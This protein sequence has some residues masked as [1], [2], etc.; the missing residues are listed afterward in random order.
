MIGKRC[1]QKR[2]PSPL[3]GEHL[4]FFVNDNSLY[5]FLFRVAFVRFA[6]YLL[7]E[8]VCSFCLVFKT[9]VSQY[10][11]MKII[12]YFSSSYC[13]KYKS[14]EMSFSNETPKVTPTAKGI[15]CVIH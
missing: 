3:W 6:D 8:F 5:V 14:N 1:F 7:E 9:S 15:L 10:R 13:S 2:C 4:S 11:R 12:Y